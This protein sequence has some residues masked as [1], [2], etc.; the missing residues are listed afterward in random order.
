VEEEVTLKHNSDFKYDLKW[1]KVGE[2]VVVDIV[3]GDSTEV[4]SERDKWIKSGNHFCEYSSRGKDS[5]ILTTNA[6]Y[7]SVNF[8]K[9]NRLFF[10]ITLET[11]S[12][13]DIIKKNKFKKM[14]GGDSNTSWGYLIPIAELI[15]VNNY[16]NN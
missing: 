15:N 8:Y 7:W 16:E 1:G 4:K 13:K 14:P 9:K 6:K 11:L 2:K 5:G 12:L 3:E 10:N